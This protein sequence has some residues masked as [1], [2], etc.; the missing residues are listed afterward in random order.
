MEYGRF[1]EDERDREV[2]NIAA[3]IQMESELGFG[4]FGDL[5]DLEGYLHFNLSNKFSRKGYQAS[6]GIVIL[7]TMQGTGIGTQLMQFG[8]KE[9]KRLGYKKIW[10]HVHGWNERAKKLYLRFG[11]K[12]E[13]VFEKDEF[14]DGKLT[15]TLSMAR[16]L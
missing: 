2:G 8:L 15:D 10:L 12:V 7:P 16:F 13:G 14:F 11:F 6:L 1:N 9:M 5:G 4:Y 3:G